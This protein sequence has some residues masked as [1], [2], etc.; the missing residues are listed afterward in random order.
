M[1]KESLDKLRFD[2]RLRHRRGWVGGDEYSQELE[3]LADV[4]D[5][6]APL[7]EERDAGGRA[8]DGV[9]ER[10]GL[11]RDQGQVRR[12]AGSGRP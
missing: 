6:V 1:N 8:R 7:D 4:S 11:I 3:S 12:E 2:L 5:K 9:S 10:R